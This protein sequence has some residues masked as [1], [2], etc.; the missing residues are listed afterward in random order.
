MKYKKILHG[1]YW[2]SWLMRTVAPVKFYLF[3]YFFLKFG[4]LNI[5]FVRGKFFW[6]WPQ[7][8]PHPMAPTDMATLWLNWS[9]G[10]DSV[11]FR[12]LKKNPQKFQK[13]KK[14]DKNKY[15]FFNHLCFGFQFCHLRRLVFGQSSSVQPFH[16]PGGFLWAWQWSRDA[17]RHLFTR[18]RFEQKSFYSKKAVNYDKYNLQ[19]N[20]VKRPKR[21]L[22]QKRASK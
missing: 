1:R 10:V 20:S 22:V 2:I 6:R 16:N 15:I 17:K 9:S 11:K 18:T 13:R 14:S 3:I 8:K 4:G 19:Q 5:F 21:Q 12:K 7:E